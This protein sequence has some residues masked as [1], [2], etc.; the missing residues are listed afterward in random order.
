MA[1]FLFSGVAHELVI[2]VPA[3][4]GYG[5][6]TLYFLFQGLG[7]IAERKFELRHTPAGGAFL[8]FVLLAPAFWLFHPPFMNA[9]IDPFL[10]FL[11]ST[12]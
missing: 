3:S 4:G 2:S 8:W 12:H 9:V 1:G 11:T 7:V 5:L 10:A 6:P